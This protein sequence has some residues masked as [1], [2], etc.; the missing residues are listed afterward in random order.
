VSREEDTS[1]LELAGS[2][3]SVR[4]YQNIPAEKGDSDRHGKAHKKLEEI[5]SWR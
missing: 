1:F 4:H 3:F 5:V 2:R